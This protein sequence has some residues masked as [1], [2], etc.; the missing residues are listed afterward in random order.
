M[1]YPRR[2]PH[3]LNGYDYSRNGCVY[4]TICTYKRQKILS[5]ICRG[6]VVENGIK[7]LEARFNIRVNPYV[8]MPD[9]IHMMLII[10]H[11]VKWEEQ[12]PSPTGVDSIICAFKSL[13]TKIANKTDNCPGRKIWQRDYYD[14]IIRNE[15]DYITKVKYILNNPR[16]AQNDENM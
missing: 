15:Y 1:A 2:K 7:E 16:N 6:G 4:I 3:R 14:H 9:H 13:T 11:A 12:S 5:E 10:D 8:I